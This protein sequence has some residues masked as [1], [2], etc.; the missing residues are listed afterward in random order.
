MKRPWRCRLSIAALFNCSVAKSQFRHRPEYT[1]WNI[2]PVRKNT[3]EVAQEILDYWC[4]VA[5]RKS[6]CGLVKLYRIRLANSLRP[7]N[8]PNC[9]SHARILSLRECMNDT[10]M[11]PAT[12]PDR[13]SFRREPNGR[14]RPPARRGGSPPRA[15]WF[16]WRAPPWRWRRR[17][18]SRWSAP[19]P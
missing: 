11:T 7:E 17:A 2:L 10:G 5:E 13:S 15:A 1:V 9:I 8:R 16:R 18:H 12:N 4:R 19:M 14:I 3:H 6:L